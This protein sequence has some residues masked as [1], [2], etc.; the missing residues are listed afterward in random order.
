[1]P[2]WELSSA[3]YF[4]E[5]AVAPPPPQA[6]GAPLVAARGATALLQGAMPADVHY[7]V[8]S[9]ATGGE[10]PARCESPGADGR[11]AVPFSADYAFYCCPAPPPA[12][13]PPTTFYEASLRGCPGALTPGSVEPPPGAELFTTLNVTGFRAFTCD[14]EGGVTDPGQYLAGG[15]SSAAPLIGQSKQKTSWKPNNQ[16]TNQPLTH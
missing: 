16:P 9:N 14:A 7:V 15:V 1:M 3:F 12:P 5:Y 6:P 8:R 2:I 13:L 10:T 11:Q 4:G